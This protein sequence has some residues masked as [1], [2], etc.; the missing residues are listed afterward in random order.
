MKTTL[1]FLSVF[2]SASLFGQQMTYVPDDN[3]EEFLE[4]TDFDP[5][6]MP[7]D[8]VETSMLESLLEFSSEGFSDYIQDFRGLEAAVNIESLSITNY[9]FLGLNLEPLPTLHCPNLT[10][11]ELWNSWFPGNLDLSHCPNIE[12]LDMQGTVFTGLNVDGLT[13]LTFIEA[14]GTD[15]YELDVSSC[16]ALTTLVIDENINLSCLNLANGNNENFI[17]LTYSS[18]GN[19][20]CVTVDDPIWA[21]ENW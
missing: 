3:F 19:L 4:N 10:Y 21:N 7:D 11:V 17:L 15:I 2:L 8:S 13:S 18:G 20:S 9:E 12:Y 6:W 14:Y 1:L 16:S 5:N